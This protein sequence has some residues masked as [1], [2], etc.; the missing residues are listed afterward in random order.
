MLPMAAIGTPCS[1]GSSQGGRGL[2]RRLKMVIDIDAHL[3]EPRDM[4][5]RYVPSRKK[6]HA[7]QIVDDALG[8]PM[9]SYKGYSPHGAYCWMGSPQRDADGGLVL[10]SQIGQ[11]Q[12]DQR[13]GI[14]AKTRYDDLEP[15]YTQAGARVALMD[16]WGIDE[17][18]IFP[19]WGLEYESMFFREDLEGLRLN[20]SAWNRFGADIV[21]E[22]AGRL[23][24]VAHLSLQGDQ[25]WVIRE[26]Q[27]ISAAGMKLAMFSPGLINGKRMSHPD[28]APIWRAFIEHDVTV[29]FHI[30]INGQFLPPAWVENDHATF[31]TLMQGW[32]PSGAML[33]LSDLVLNGTLADH[34]DLRVCVVELSGAKWLPTWLPSLD[35]TYDMQPK[36]AGWNVRTLDQRP[37]DYVRRQVRFSSLIHEPTKAS[38]ESVGD[39]FAFSSDWPHPE[40]LLDPVQEFGAAV[41]AADDAAHAKFWSGN[42][43]WALGRTAA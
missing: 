1:G 35:A 17:Q 20:A 42:A 11:P 27:Q 18:V 4:W 36:I 6:S 21:V 29:T 3:Y 10:D 33:G 40:G 12:R 19:Q 39:L 14:P 8:Y 15:A 24:P 2:G 34:P 28:N 16:K 32:F 38:I 37:S 41:G 30:S 7:V 13:D 26:I 23:H 43:A 22:S 9:L 25:A 31:A 5:S